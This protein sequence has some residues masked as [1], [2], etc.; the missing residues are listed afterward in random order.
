MSLLDKI[1][2]SMSTQSTTPVVQDRTQQAQQMMQA[3]LGKAATTESTPRMS[4]IAEMEVAGKVA[5]EQR[6]LAEKGEISAQKVSQAEEKVEQKK[7]QGTQILNEERLNQV[8]SYQNR[9]DSIM[10]ELE[11]NKKQLDAKQYR[12]KIEQLGFNLRLQNDQ[13]ID[14][15]EREGVTARLHQ[16]SYMNEELLRT[17]FAEELDLYNNDLDFRSLV[18][19]YDRDAEKA[20]ARI[21]INFA[22]ELAKSSAKAEGTKM[23]FQGLATATTGGISAW[24]KYSSSK[25][26]K[27]TTSE[28]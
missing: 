5:E 26:T 25:S 15:L 6:K 28:G 17:V 1:R 16:E 22:I 8:A 7:L 3:K 24:D 11:R 2:Q 10:G 27:P 20:L 4:N 18:N 9:A 23:I 13:Y 21:D 12:A 19:A 14:R